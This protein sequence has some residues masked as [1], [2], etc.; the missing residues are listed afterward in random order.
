MTRINII[1]PLELTDQHLVAEYR[2]IFMIG[3]SLQRSLKSKNWNKDKIP[4]QYTLNK[5]HVMF[6]YDKG[7]YL[8]NRYDQLRNEM[9]NRNMNPNPDRIFPLEHFPLDYQNDWSPRL[10]DFD[11]AR[12]RIDLRISQRSNWYRYNGKILNSI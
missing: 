10:V 6:F 12:E 4:T 8:Y 11:I 1:P 3:P 7:R 2:E 9:I 5:G